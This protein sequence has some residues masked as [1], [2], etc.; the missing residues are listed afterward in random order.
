MRT[1]G[2]S[3]EHEREALRVSALVQFPIPALGTCALANRGYSTARSIR[4]VADAGGR[5]IV[6]V[7]TESLLLC[8]AGGRPFV[9]LTAGSVQPQ[10]GSTASCSWRRWA[11]S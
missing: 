4:D 10:R 7:N 6:H 5:L 9:L 1:T 2:L 8:T 11:R 3:R